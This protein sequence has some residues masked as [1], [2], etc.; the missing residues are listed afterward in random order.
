MATL[1]ERKI[2]NDRSRYESIKAAALFLVTAI[3]KALVTASATGRRS[4]YCSTCTSTEIKLNVQIT[5]AGGS[6]AQA[7]RFKEPI[8]TPACNLAARNRPV[9]G[10]TCA[11]VLVSRPD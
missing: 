9:A 1:K 8:A 10:A 4:A 5:P 3:R 11:P 7:G 2:L 6:V